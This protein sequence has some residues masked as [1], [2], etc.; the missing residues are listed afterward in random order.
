MKFI[1]Y[2]NEESLNNIHDAMEYIKKH[3]RPYIM[4]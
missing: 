4:D 1:N 2:L 3:C